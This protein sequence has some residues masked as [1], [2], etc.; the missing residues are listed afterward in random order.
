VQR[1]LAAVGFRFV[2]E[3]W[4]T[5]ASKG[6]LVRLWSPNAGVRNE[7]GR[8]EISNGTCLVREIPATVGPYADGARLPRD[9][10]SNGSAEERRTLWA[11]TARATDRTIALLRLFERGDVARF[12][13]VF[14]A[15]RPCRFDSPDVR[16][17]PL[18][19]WLLTQTSALNS[20]G[21]FDLHSLISNAPGRRGTAFNTERQLHVGLHVDSWDKGD[22]ASLQAARN[23]IAINVGTEP[24]YLVFINIPIV[25]MIPLLGAPTRFADQP[26]DA[27][28]DAFMSAFPDYPA[29][30]LRVDPGEAYVAPTEAIAHEGSTEGATVAD[31][32][33]MVRG[34]FSFRSPSLLQQSTLRLRSLVGRSSQV[35]GP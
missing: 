28:L 6:R 27:V 18:L 9:P 29:I 17:D 25:E 32:V 3:L 11:P 10:W 33:V 30:R 19:A 7:S 21:P 35:S 5:L 1:A 26:P 12:S 31:R 24:R 13:D 8:A 2:H 20:R 15:I 34:Y 16:A 4:R 22:L 14:S 23:R